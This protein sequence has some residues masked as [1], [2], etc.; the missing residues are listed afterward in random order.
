MFAENPLPLSGEIRLT[1]D[2]MSVAAGRPEK[3]VLAVDSLPCPVW[4]FPGETAGE[5]VIGT[6]ASLPGGC[7][8]VKVEI[9][10]APDPENG[11]EGETVFRVHLSQETGI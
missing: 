3:T 5:S 1:P 10:V 4:S 8:G 2:E 7:R 9:M 6:V 11:S